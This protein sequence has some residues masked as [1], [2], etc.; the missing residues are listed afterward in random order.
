M[1]SNPLPPSTMRV[2]HGNTTARV[3]RAI[4]PNT[5]QVAVGTLK[6]GANTAR[7]GP[8]S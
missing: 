1:T 3:I 2:V 5:G 4:L 6:N 7:R 8:G